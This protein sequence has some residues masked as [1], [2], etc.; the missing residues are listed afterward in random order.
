[1]KNRYILNLDSYIEKNGYVDL[2]LSNEAEHESWGFT[3]KQSNYWDYPYT[4]LYS[5]ERHRK[6]QS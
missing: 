1:L 2:S 5:K 4:T 3:Q 6:I